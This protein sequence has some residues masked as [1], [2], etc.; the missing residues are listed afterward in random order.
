MQRY[1]WP[2]K[3]M[4]VFMKHD[5]ILYIENI[6]SLPWGQIIQWS[7]CLVLCG[8]T[9][10]LCLTSKSKTKIQGRNVQPRVKLK[11]HHCQFA[12]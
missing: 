12:S 6:S 3:L 2:E 5:L 9:H 7:P 4:G 10:C 11:H 8:D 1:I